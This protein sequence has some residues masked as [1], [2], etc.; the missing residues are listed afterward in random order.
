MWC[1]GS[2]QNSLCFPPAWPSPAAPPSA[3]SP[4]PR[5]CGP[6]TRRR[7]STQRRGVCHGKI[8]HAGETRTL[9]AEAEKGFFHSAPWPLFWEGERADWSVPMETE[10]VSHLSGV[11]AELPVETL[12]SMLSELSRLRVSYAWPPLGGDW[13]CRME[14]CTVG[15]RPAQQKWLSK[16]HS[17]PYG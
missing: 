11:Q 2:R 6:L 3:S 15:D 4:S 8:Q 5:S 7:C 14:W 9:K 16:A 12:V 17:D 13:W 1:P 10:S